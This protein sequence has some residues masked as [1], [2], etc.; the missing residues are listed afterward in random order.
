MNIGISS[1]FNPKE[2]E[3]WLDKGQIIP[4]CNK[5]ASSV[6]AY[7]EELLLAGHHVTIFT[8]YDFDGEPKIITGDLLKI[9]IVS[10]KSKF[11]LKNGGINAYLNRFYVGI[12]LA[13]KI[14]NEIN[15]LDVLHGQWTYDF[16]LATCFF[17]RKIPV[18]CSVRDWCPYQY[19]IQTSRS[20]KIYWGVSYIVFKIV[21]AN[22]K[23][24][25]IANSQYTYNCIK[26]NYP[27][28]IVHVIPNPIKRNYILTERK[29]YPQTTTFIS[30]SQ[31]LTEERKN[32]NN[33]LIAF[34]KYK[35]MFENSKLLLIGRFSENSSCIKKWRDNSLNGVSL[36]GFIEHDKIKEYL[37]QSTHL[38]HPS[39]EETFGNT[40][41]EGFARRLVVIGGKDSG[42]V[43]MVLGNGEY[44]LLCDVKSPDSIYTTMLK[45]T[46][47]KEYD[48]MLNKATTYLIKNYRADEIAKKHLLL[49]LDYTHQR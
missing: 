19:S 12:R 3:N 37:D 38:I 29:D 7:V 14:K 44:G 27:N 22:R 32:Y 26:N 47:I 45:A 25:F 6:H 33:L 43:P 4:N 42:A 35:K 10:R 40:L 18:F 1:T 16:S 17:T 30:I 2:F 15:N 28:N 21:M 46:K 8:T 49:Y 9:Y 39:L 48:I 34:Q 41:L 24:I 11:P 20:N 23:I 13:K 31:S 5:A 36:L